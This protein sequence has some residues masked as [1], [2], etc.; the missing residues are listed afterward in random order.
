MTYINELKI[1]GKKIKVLI[2][3]DD[4]NIR[5]DLKELLIHFFCKVDVACDGEEAIK[6]YK[7]NKYCIVIT[8]YD[9]PNKNGIDFAK[10]IKL[11]NR[12]QI[13][14]VMSAH[15]GGFI[16]EFIDIG[17]SSFI[18]K[19]IDIES[20]MLTLLT[21]CENIIFKRELDRIKLNKNIQKENIS[22]IK[23]PI[24]SIVIDIAKNTNINTTI[25]EKSIKN[26]DKE[27]LISDGMWEN[28]AEDISELNGDFEDLIDSIL[29]YG[30]KG[31]HLES[32][33]IILY[34]YYTSL[35]LLDIEDMGFLLKDFADSL[36]SVNIDDINEDSVVEMIEFL[37]HDIIDY[38]NNIFISNSTQD[39][40]YLTDSMRSSLYQMK[41]ELRIEKQKEEDHDI[42][43]F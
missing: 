31:S 38:F 22:S 25:E 2:V 34:K 35:H 36:P 10:E 43:L 28:M 40:N 12:N 3:D 18:K 30:I 29:L 14:I 8:D 17:I 16:V 20:F 27:S 24:K 4:E 39:I 41:I 42:D 11:I 6:K 1:Y 23:S 15:F 9:M 33:N 13:I 5:R 37:C 26:N 21:H 7:N 32:L 19:P